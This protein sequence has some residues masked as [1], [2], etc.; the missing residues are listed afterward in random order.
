[1]KTIIIASLILVSAI[2]YSQETKITKKQVPQP[3]MTAFKSAYPKAKIIGTNKEI[4]NGTTY[5]E[6][7]SK[8]G[9]TK[10]N[11]LYT[12]DGSLYV[13]EE[14]I[15]IKDLPT[16]VRSSFKSNYSKAKIKVI[17]KIMK[18]SDITYEIQYRSGKQRKEAVFSADGKEVK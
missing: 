14:V 13:T 16:V 9:K 6:I 5:Y 18:G 11:V 17:E 8:D 10:R 3:A 1:M 7:E 12:S 4:E 15:G 2:G